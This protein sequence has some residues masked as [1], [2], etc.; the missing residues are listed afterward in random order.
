MIIGVLKEF[1]QDEKRVS[2]T[3]ETVKKYKSMGLEVYVEKDAGLLSNFK[4]Y[5]YKEAGSEIKASKE[6][7]INQCDIIILVSSIPDQDTIDK[8]KDNCTIIGMFN[9]YEN[10]NKLKM[11]ETKKL[12]VISLD[13]LP[14]I[15][16]AQSMD[17]LSSQANLAG[18]R[19]VI[20]ASNIF[21]KA[22]PMMMTAAG[23]IAPAKCLVIGAG[24]A[25]L[26]SIAT[27]K[28]LGCMVSAF[29][30]RP[31]VEEQVKS[32]GAKFVKV[33]DNNKKEEASVYAK[34]M[35]K[36]Y[37]IKQLEKIHT[38]AKES[39]IIITTA[40]I[41]G[42]PA[43]KLISSDTIK[44]MKNGSVI[45]D[46]AGS[47]GG[48]TEETKFRENINLNGV[49]IY[50][51]ANLPSSISYDSSLLFSKNILNFVTHIIGEEKIIDFNSEDEI[52]S[53]SLLLKHGK[54]TKNLFENNE[55]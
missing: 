21:R 14:R 53:K 40:L 44:E 50:S 39:D 10:I 23:T 13:L 2:A 31:E 8:I 35:S 48:N 18:Y 33:D 24:V 45:I 27:A 7:I 28:R 38:V 47:A 30:V 25:G 54:K 19:A 55:W 29:D 37:K 41:P 5:L 1:N 36:D 49:N 4:D 16:R 3:P 51:P 46:L 43:P 9:P 32:L 12:N 22:L 15:S 26:Q 11:L 17:V 20:E 42:K 52:I 6:E 34:E